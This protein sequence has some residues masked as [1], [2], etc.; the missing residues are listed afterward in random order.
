MNYI[1]KAFDHLH[2][3]ISPNYQGKSNSFTP[4]Y[5]FNITW[6][7]HRTLIFFLFTS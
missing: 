1:F 4:G 7:F 6:N 5:A 3:L 2:E